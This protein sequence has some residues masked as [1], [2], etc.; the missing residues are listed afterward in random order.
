MINYKV[1]QRRKSKN[2]G[3]NSVMRPLIV[4]VGIQESDGT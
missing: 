2:H 3:E 4:Y 1:K